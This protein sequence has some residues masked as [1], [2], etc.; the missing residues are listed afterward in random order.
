MIGRMAL[1]GVFTLRAGLTCLGLI[2]A[3]PAIADPH[4][5]AQKVLAIGGSITEIIYALDQQDR[6]IA[7]DSTSSYPEAALALP[8]V[9]Y[10][11]Q[12][13]PEG[14]LSVGPDLILSEAGAGPPEAIAL[15]QESGVPFEVMPDGIGNGALA[16][17]VQAVADTLGVPEAAAPV[18]QGIEA[19]LSQL[20]H[21]IAAL[22]DPPRKV[23]FVLTVAD[24]RINASG[25]GTEANEI[26]RMAGAENAVP[27]F[28]GYK[29]LTD[30]AIIEAA[31]DVILTMAR[32]GEGAGMDATVQ[33]LLA[34]PAIAAT[35][36]GRNGRIVT[37]NGLYLLGFGPRTGQAALELHDAI[38]AGP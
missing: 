22:N 37:M 30:E 1:T 36:A 3:F 13:S 7:R 21:N 12:L 8:D 2:A 20:E 38:Y 14:V 27:D 18:I 26:I 15:L 29:Q 28:E 10:M 34:V 5:E 4:P 11:R 6:L 16:G 35:P 24:G 32:G 31:P 9:G 33:E 23:L 25:T 19:D 17:K